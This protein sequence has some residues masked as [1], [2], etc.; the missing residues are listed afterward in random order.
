MSPASNSIVANGHTN[1]T[2]GV[3]AHPKNWIPIAEHVLGKPQRK[4]RVISIGCG[5][6][7]LTLA[8]KIQNVF[9]I[10]DIV[11][12][13]LYEKNPDV[14]G[15][16]FENSYATGQD[17]QNYLVKIKKQHNLDR[18]VV[19]DS[20]VIE[21]IW[22]EG[23]G[24]WHVKVEQKG[25]TIIQDTCD[26]L[27]NGSGVLN[28][29]SWPKILGLRDFK[30]HLSHS[31]DWKSWQN[32]VDMT[33]MRVGVVGN[34]SSGMQIVPEVTKVASQCFNFVR[35]G[36]WI[37]APFVEEL[38]KAPGTNPEY[39][40]EEKDEFRRNPAK[41]KE[42]RHTLAQAFNHFYEAL[43]KGSAA[44]K[45]AMEATKAMMADR[46]KAKPEMLE[47]LVPKW[48]L[49][50]RRLTPGHGY[51]EAVTKDNF[52]LV[53]GDIA[54]VT[55]KG[56]M[57]TNGKEYELDALICA[58]GF[59]VSFKPRWLQV[60][61]Q[62]QN[63]AKV[64]EDDA[65]GYFSL[66]VSGQPNYFIFNGPAG[67][68]GHGSLSSAIDWE[69]NYIIKWLQKMAREDIKSF[70][71]KKSVQDDWN[72]WGDELL[73]RTVWSSGCRSWYKSGTRDGRITAL[74]PG[75]ILHFKDMVED[76]RGEDFDITY[77]SKN[78][79]KFLGDGFTQLEVDNGDLGYYIEC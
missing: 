17:I 60:G 11:D 71:V 48:D 20:R 26:V 1:D 24:K 74:Y 68:V 9:K 15:T 19:Y 47:K 4:L 33:G 67:P 32:A 8:H 37:S 51:L 43:I 54:R 52:E 3:S 61:R 16:W 25:S 41:L 23:E 45:S 14:G 77:T 75:S 50:C 44:N 55:P 38:S 34:G 72:V 56:V 5:F 70:D 42:H 62:G 79:W 21:A 40:Q 22:I 18:E 53:V 12:L 76:I 46:L 27:I 7:G 39:T 2:N 29:W 63:L 66:C 69:A 58:T 57:M 64:W 30:G 13:V 65:Q 28:A 35:E 73:K 31:A 78:Q 59:D 36:T 49:G 10:D 6:S